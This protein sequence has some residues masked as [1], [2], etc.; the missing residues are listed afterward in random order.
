MPPSEAET[1]LVP[2]GNGSET[3]TAAASDGPALSTVSVYV[4][5]VPAV[6]GS[7]ESDFVSDRSALCVTVS[8]SLALLLPA[9]GSVVPA[10]A[11]VAVFVSVPAAELFTVP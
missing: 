1:K 11:A 10:A 6:T 5:F 3:D 2:A 8:L 4:R 7:G 9:V